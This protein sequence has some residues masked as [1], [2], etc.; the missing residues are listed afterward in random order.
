MGSSKILIKENF[1][2][3]GA[4]LNGTT[5][6]TFDA[7]I[8]AAGGSSTWVAAANFL[9]NGVVTLATK[10]AA[11]LNLGSYIN[12]AKGTVDGKF[13]VTMTISPTCGWQKRR[14]EGKSRHRFGRS[15]H[16][17]LDSWTWAECTGGRPQFV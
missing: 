9:D 1:G 5:T 15:I 16:H 4:A 8:T 6:D 13:N 17:A 11:Y 3:T 2:G 12:N 10:Q 14:G 7:A